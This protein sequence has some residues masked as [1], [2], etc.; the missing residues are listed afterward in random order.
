M[1]RYVSTR[2]PPI[3]EGAPR[4]SRNLARAE[5]ER[6]CDLALTLGADAPTLCGDWTVKDLLAHLLV[7]ERDPI[8]ASG[9]WMPGLGKVTEWAM[10]R[11]ARGDLE[12]L[13]QKLRS[14]GL[15]PVNIPLVDKAFNTLEFYIHHEDIRR[16]Q[17]SWEPRELTSYEHSQIW[18]ALKT[19]GRGLVRNAGVP[20]AMHRTDKDKRFVLKRGKDPVTVSG[21]PSEVALFLYGRP[22]HDGVTLDG[23]EDSVATLESSSLGL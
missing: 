22:H 17:P 18:A 6:L 1:L 10:D 4:Q 20:L 13:V 16:A 7:R 12:D 21:L 2:N 15:S 11:T 23:P 9:I 5:R 19:M 8:G 3:E 14:P